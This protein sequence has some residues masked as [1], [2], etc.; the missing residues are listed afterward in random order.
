VSAP[1]WPPAADAATQ[2]TTV[3]LS[4]A[5]PDSVEVRVR[6]V[7][8]WGKTV[9][10]NDE[11][12]VWCSFCGGVFHT[13]KRL[14]S[15]FNRCPTGIVRHINGPVEVDL[16]PESPDFVGDPPRYVPVTG[17]RDPFWAPW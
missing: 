12:E 16:D 17:P 14:G 7:R 6:P 13:V 9:L 11:G 2:W 5:W 15:P 4:A 3:R 8:L 1:E 10:I